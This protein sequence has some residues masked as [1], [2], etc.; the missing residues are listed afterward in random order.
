MKRA[1]SNGVDVIYHCELADEEALD[2]LEAAKDRIFVG[3]AVGLL[4]NTVYEAAEFGMTPEVARAWACSA[5]SRSRRTYHAMRKRGIRVVIG[6]D[7]GFAWTPQGTNARDLEHFV[8]LFGY[9]PTEALVVRHAKV[10]GEMM[11]DELGQVREGYLADLLL[12]DGDPS[13]D[14]AD[15]AGPRPAGD[16][17]E[18][19]RVPQASAHGAADARGAGG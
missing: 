13:R 5:T 3:P 15:H 19:R 6:G 14:V 11:G 8:N 9:S 4:H 12:V 1:V 7:Y 10:G 2:M 17:H 16:D 18:G